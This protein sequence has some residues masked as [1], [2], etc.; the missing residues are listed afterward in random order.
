MK[1]R[2]LS[3]FKANCLNKYISIPDF[4]LS[5]RITYPLSACNCWARSLLGQKGSS[6]V[7]IL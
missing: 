5:Y 6:C 1:E 3:L 2:K 4:H 7:E